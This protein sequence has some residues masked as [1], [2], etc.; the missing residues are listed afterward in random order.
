MK[1]FKIVKIAANENKEIKFTVPYEAFKTYND[2]GEEVFTPGEY[3]IYV[4]STL[5][6][7]RSEE[8]GAPKCRNNFV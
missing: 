3:E 6:G 2:N 1:D 4:G 5:P 8:L 7:K